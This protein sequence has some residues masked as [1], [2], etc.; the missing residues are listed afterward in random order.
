M[1]LFLK[2]KVHRSSQTGIDWRTEVGIEDREWS[3][4]MG[5]RASKKEM[6]QTSHDPEKQPG[7]QRPMADGVSEKQ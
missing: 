6:G 7:K 5:V 3:G 2:M 4:G 1:S